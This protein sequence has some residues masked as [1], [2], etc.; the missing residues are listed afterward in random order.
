MNALIHWK[1]S[2]VQEI[3]KNVPIKVFKATTHIRIQGEKT[4]TEFSQEYKTMC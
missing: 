2:L 3:G 1:E 4:I